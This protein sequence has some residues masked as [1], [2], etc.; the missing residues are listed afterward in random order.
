MDAAREGSSVE[1]APSTESGFVHEEL[2]L[3]DRV[4]GLRDTYRSAKW[5]ID[6]DRMRYFTEAYKE[7][8]GEFPAIR[9]AKGTRLRSPC[10]LR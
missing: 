3:S 6:I 9:N 2:Y 7:T 5:Q 8:E 10:M 1:K 4:K